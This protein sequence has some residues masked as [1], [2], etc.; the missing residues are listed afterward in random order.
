VPAGGGV[1]TGR[2]SS[3][4][5]GRHW[6]SHQ[7]AVWST[8]A[9]AACRPVLVVAGHACVSW[10]N[11]CYFVQAWSCAWGFKGTNLMLWLS[12]LLIGCTCVIIIHNLTLYTLEL[13][14][15]M[16]H[17]LRCTHVHEINYWNHYK[18]IDYRALSHFNYSIHQ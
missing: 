9:T 3:T 12:W 11:L 13:L 18:I 15:F 6:P 14:I 5:T 16:D 7:P 2:W 4:A 17:F 1:G 8:T 10:T